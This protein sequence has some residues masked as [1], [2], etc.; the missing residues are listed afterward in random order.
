MFTKEKIVT[1]YNGFVW[2][3][4][5]ESDLGETYKPRGCSNTEE[6][7]V[8]EL[9]TELIESEDINDWD[10]VLKYATKGVLMSKKT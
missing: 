9:L 7:A 3:A 10:V 1:Y 5:L 8:Y 2:M 6:R 4:E